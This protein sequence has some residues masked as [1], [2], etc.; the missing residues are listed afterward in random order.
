MSFEINGK[1]LNG[2]RNTNN[3]K[4]VQIPW[5]VTKINDAAFYEEPTIE[6]VIIPE[7]VTCI[8]WY[9]F[10]SCSSLKEI[11]IPKRVYYGGRRSFD[12]KQRK[13]KRYCYS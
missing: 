13:R 4:C 12:W 11:V 3:E 7:T 10:E 9:A 5:G 2:Y 8:S 6:K 1:V